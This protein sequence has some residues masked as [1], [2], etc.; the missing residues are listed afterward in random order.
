MASRLRRARRGLIGALAIAGAAL[1]AGC[2]GG[3]PAATDTAAP[4][5][6]AA[7][8]SADTLSGELTVFAAASLNQ[9]FDEIA[10][11]FMAEHPETSITFNYGGSSG[12]VTQMQDG[13]PVD[14]LAT[15]NEST[16]KNAI[17]ASLMSAEQP[18]FATNVLTVVVEP[19]NPK[20][21]TGL[22]DLTRD[23]VALVVCAEQVPCGAATNKLEETTGITLSPVSEENAVTDV[24]GKITTGQADAGIVY[25][26]DAR[27]AGD[28]VAEVVIPEAAD[29]VNNYP[30]GVTASTTN[31]ELAQAFVDYVLAA[32][33]QQ[34]LQA[35]G[36]GAP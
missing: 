8:P 14:V 1:L 17:E 33:A 16:M 35:A 18:I 36:F 24:L 25:V 20:N 5:D 28:Q 12:L 22:S 21:I 10:A 9:V 23:D 26:T 30:I 34:K 32:S 4:A 19:G 15:A 13:A 27:G 31:P 3:A 6:A 29:I 7:A 2:A 11:D